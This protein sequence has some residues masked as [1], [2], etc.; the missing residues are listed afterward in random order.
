MND[1]LLEKMKAII[2]WFE[3]SEEVKSPSQLMDE[4]FLYAKIITAMAKEQIP[5]ENTDYSIS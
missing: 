5:N 2:R 1:E 4:D 3:N